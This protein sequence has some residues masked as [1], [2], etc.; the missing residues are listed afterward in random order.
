MILIS[1]LGVVPGL[2]LL[3][4]KVLEVLAT[5]C[6]GM[7]NA[8]KKKFF[9]IVFQLGWLR[10]PGIRRAFVGLFQNFGCKSNL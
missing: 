1:K 2:F 5:N 10:K 4:C 8:M 6:V 7:Q 9:R 3:K